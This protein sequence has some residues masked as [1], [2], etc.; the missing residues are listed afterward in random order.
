MLVVLQHPAEAIVIGEV[1]PQLQVIL[2]RLCA[3]GKIRRGD[4]QSLVGLRVL[5]DSV[6]RPD[7]FDADAI[8]GRVTLALDQGQADTHGTLADGADVKS[9]VF[10]ESG[11]LNFVALIAEQL[12]YQFLEFSRI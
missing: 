7:K 6:E 5:G 3:S 9:A 8:G 4:E 12:G 10:A 11:K 1:Q 2:K